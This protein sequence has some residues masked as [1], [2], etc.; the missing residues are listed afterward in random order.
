MNDCLAKLPRSSFVLLPAAVL[1]CCAM[2]CGSGHKND[3]DPGLE[4][5]VPAVD[6]T[7]EAFAPDA[8]PDADAPAEDTAAPDLADAPSTDEGNVQEDAAVEAQDATDDRDSAAPDDLA[9]DALPDTPPDALPDA[10][11]DA[12]TDALPDALADA[13]QPDAVADLPAETTDLPPAIQAIDHALDAGF[14]QPNRGLALKMVAPL[15]AAIPSDAPTT[16]QQPWVLQAELKLP[17]GRTVPLVRKDATYAAIYDVPDYDDDYLYVTTDSEYVDGRYTY[18]ANLMQ[19]LSTASWMKSSGTGTITGHYFYAI[20]YR[21]GYFGSDTWVVCP[22]LAGSSP[23]SSEMQV[24]FEA[25]TL[26][27]GKPLGLMVNSYLSDDRNAI[28]SLSGVKSYAEACYCYDVSQPG[29]PQR[30]CTDADIDQLPGMPQAV[31]PAD[32][33]EGVATGTTLKWASTGDPDGGGV[34]YDVWFG[35]DNPPATRIW[36]GTS[37]TSWTPTLQP[38]TTYY[39]RVQASDNEGNEV[40]S[41]V[42]TFNTDTT[43]P[44]LAQHSYLIVV[45]KRLQGRID[46]A[47]D[48][49]VQDVL[50]E[51]AEVPAVRWWMP[52]GHPQLK[53]LIRDSWQKWGIHGVF[54]V[55]D[56]PSAWYEQDPDFGDPVGVVHEEFPTELYFQQM[57]GDWGDANGNGIYD[58]HPGIDLDLFSARLVGGADRINAY[59]ARLHQYRTNGSFFAQR[60]FFSFV[61]DDWNGSRSLGYADPSTTGGTWGLE[62][63]YGSRYVRR[64][65]SDTTGK[66]DYLDVM[67][68]G[69]G[70]E[71]VYQWIHSDPQRIYFD[72]NF[73]PNPQN[74]LTLEEL[75]ARNVQGSFFNLFDCS[76]S[77]YTEPDGNLASEYVHGEKGLAAVGSTKAGGIF[78]PDVLHGA[79]HDGLGF[80]EALRLWFND[81]W[82]Y[83]ASY[84]F[85]EVFFDGW[86]LGMMVQGD[87]LVTLQRPATTPI[88][89]REMPPMRWSPDQLGRLNAILRQQARTARVH[90][91]A[92]SVLRRP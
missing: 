90:G 21:S 25:D 58:S 75:V 1:A 20:V 56:L 81:T 31:Q 44:V 84:G 71:F 36:H 30:A 86:W 18:T 51:G 41:P 19:T 8:E 48:R 42:W 23:A 12:A 74:L 34:T 47:L 29:Y 77:R 49:Y 17:S 54:L 80:G 68:G 78:N 16:A 40:S 76:I 72:D 4:D 35:T 73:S 83:R 9:G 63:F 22:V 85:D 24:H 69:G 38:D 87:P 46:A 88:A 57:G 10:L 6:D 66:Q 32:G 28:A 45:D 82:A 91:Y 79:L 60:R 5:D 64:E 37:S 61:D 13:P 65:W 7:V 27:A 11:P 50:A 14:L 39:W 89:R 70:A 3:K 62:D 2:A 53:A 67:A 33:Q 92:D 15:L 55:G 59:L 43:L 52:G 26:Q